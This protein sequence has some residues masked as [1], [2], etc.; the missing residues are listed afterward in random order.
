VLCPT[1]AV[2]MSERPVLPEHPVTP[3]NGSSEG[4]QRRTAESI[5]LARP[6]SVRMRSVPADV[7]VGTRL[8]RTPQK[9]ASVRVR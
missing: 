6:L 7:R 5:V 4:G 3:V 9:A 1:P 8:L 2:P